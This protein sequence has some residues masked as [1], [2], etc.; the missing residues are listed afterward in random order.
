[1]AG[2]AGAPA[3]YLRTLPAPMAADCLNY[4]VQIARDVEDVGVLVTTEE[5]GD[6]AASRRHRPELRSRLER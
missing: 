2:L 5:S 6:D 3:G 1:M 4:G